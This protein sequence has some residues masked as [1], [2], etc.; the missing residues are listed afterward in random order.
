VKNK[1]LQKTVLKIMQ[2]ID[3]KAKVE[4]LEG[5]TIMV[6]ITSEESGRLIGKFGQ[7][8][9]DLQHIVRLIANQEAGE[10]VSLTVDVDSYKANK[11]RELEELAL[12][13][14]D[15]VQKSGYPQ[16]LKPM[17]AY[18]RRV[19]HSALTDFEG[20]ESISQGEEPNRYIEIKPKK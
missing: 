16:T 10:R 3:P 9:Q 18:D 2:L 14:A 5:D 15:N 12:S 19:I 11:N 8:L 7:T 4:V 17:N 1:N 13:V 20:V 6:N